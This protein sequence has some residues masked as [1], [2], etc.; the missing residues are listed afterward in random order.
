MEATEGIQLITDQDRT[1]WIS[2]SYVT[3]QINEIV[4]LSSEWA[5]L[6]RIMKQM[7][8]G[9]EQDGGEK[10]SQ[11]SQKPLHRHDLIAKTQSVTSIRRWPNMYPALI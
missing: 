6:C 11:H 9:V 7:R 8:N 2:K 1:W 4:A 10:L 5:C 3:G